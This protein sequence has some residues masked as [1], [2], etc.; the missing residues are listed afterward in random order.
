[1]EAL[2]PPGEGQYVIELEACGICRSDLI[3]AHY[4]SMDWGKVGHEFGGR[5][6]ACGPKA[7]KFK[8]GQRVA[9]KNAACCG[10]CQ[11]C[12]AGNAYDCESVIINKCGHDHFFL[13]EE[14]SLVDAGDLDPSLLALVEPLG[15]ANEVVERAEINPDSR[16]MIYGLGTLGFLAGWLCRLKGAQ[17]VVGTSR[18]NR[19]FEIAQ[20]VGFAKCQRVENHG[21]TAA[22][23]RIASNSFDR[24]L[25]FAPSECLNHAV[26]F[27]KNEGLMVI[28]G[29][30]ED[31][32]DASTKFN[33]EQLIFRRIALRGAFASPNI[34]FPEAIEQLRHHGHILKQCISHEF[35]LSEIETIYPAMVKNPHRF[36]KV[37][38]KPNIREVL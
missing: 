38:L 24:M 35:P 37:V 26:G 10:C 34:F 1:M 14:R 19:W 18:S 28:A 32:G 23:T 22:T 11:A 4:R 36:L 17:E 3:W 27:M 29:L 33:F 21:D 20:T 13:A 5:I 31:G 8:K 12:R 7:K 25:V 15:A 30:N 16:I 6:I 9:V 2:P